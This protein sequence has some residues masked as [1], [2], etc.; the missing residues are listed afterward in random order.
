[1]IQLPDWFEKHRNIALGIC[2]G[3]LMV[4]AFGLRILLLPYLTHHSILPVL[5]ADPWYTVR[6][7]ELVV[8]HYPSYSWFDPMTAF[9]R[10]KILDWGPLM[11]FIAGTVA[12]VFGA[13]TREEIL[14]IAAFIPPFIAA[15]MVPLVFMLGKVVHDWKAGLVAAAAIAIIPGGYFL[16]T[17]YGFIDHHAFEIFFSTLFC[18]LYILALRYASR[19]E[20]QIRD[21]K[22]ALPVI[23]LAIGSG[24]AYL[25]GLLVMPTI[26]VFAL[27]VALYTL[28]QHIAAPSDRKLILSLAIVNCI[29]FTLVLVVYSLLMIQRGGFSLGTY[30]VA[31]SYIY[32]LLIAGTIILSVLSLKFGHNRTQYAISLVVAG[33]AGIA[34]ILFVILVMM[35]SIGRDLFSLLSEFFGVSRAAIPIQEMEAMGLASLW[36]SY[37]VGIFLFAAGIGVLAVWWYKNRKEWYLFVLVWAI[38]ILVATLMHVRFEYYLSVLV[39]LAA[40]ITFSA[41][42]EFSQENGGLFAGKKVKKPEKK[43][44]EPEKKVRKQEK[45]ARES[46]KK[47]KETRKKDRESSF[48]RTHGMSL[49][50]LALVLFGIVSLYQDV[51][52]TTRYQS[53]LVP[54]DWSG[55]LSWLS[56]ASPDP[57]VEYLGIYPRE[58]WTYPS[59]AYGVLSLWDYGHYITVLGRRIPN[60]NPFQDNVLGRYGTTAFLMAER[61]DEAE[62]IAAR[63]GSRYIITD[64]K[65]ANTKF[66]STAAL[67]NATRQKGYY[68]RDFLVPAEDGRSY[69]TLT[70]ID[71]PYYTTMVARLHALDGSATEAEKAYYVEYREKVGALPEITVFEYL[72][73]ATA[74]GR[75]EAYAGTGGTSAAVFSTSLKSPLSR[76]PALSH[77][78]L[79]YESP[80]RDPVD[81]LS[82]VKIFERVK[83]AQIPG[84]GTIELELI[85]NQN[86]SFM[87]RQESRN[88][89]F[90]VP[91]STDQNPYPVKATG[92]YHILG[93]T[94]TYEVSEDDVILGRE[95]S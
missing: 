46:E 76:I 21:A 28:A 12:L 6:Q 72:P 8:S 78:R 58:N 47:I 75:E 67:H 85:T 70:L 65:M 34:A 48:V 45:K 59:S 55:A 49:V 14:F 89:T 2:I 90:V 22:T 83:G 62:K 57:G 32:A 77:Y 88:G 36:S 82:E 1:M 44:G 68:T 53:L 79:V 37:N 35:P 18:I 80:T 74:R 95:I 93:S 69:K 52:S 54:N 4:V 43:A 41:C 20:F 73:L 60:S 40:G 39:A 91:Y 27:I 3:V 71:S 25:L 84:E 94:R 56:G 30:T 92:P 26:L 23:L 81:G 51:T 9:P 17:T 29:T 61:E 24:I 33:C 63:L 19:R 10:G 15:L 5:G 66:S 50:L 11:P 38:L 64:N 42:V 87:Y 7:I 16:R 31:H 13:S 86:R